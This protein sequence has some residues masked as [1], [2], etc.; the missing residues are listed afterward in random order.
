[1]TDADDPAALVT[2]FA[3]PSLRVV[4]L[5]QLNALGDVAL[6]AVREGLKHPDWHVRRAAPWSRP[7]SPSRCGR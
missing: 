6:P 3:D 7:P 5:F 1:M 2:Q 4:T